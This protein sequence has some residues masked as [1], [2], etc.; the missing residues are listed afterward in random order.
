[1]T[2]E[3]IILSPVA[4]NLKK[5]LELLYQETKGMCRDF[6]I[7]VDDLEAKSKALMDSC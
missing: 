7:R 6:I 5:P 2:M 1:M 4:P 3:K